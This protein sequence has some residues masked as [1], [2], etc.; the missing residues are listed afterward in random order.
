MA[1]FQVPDIY[2]REQSGPRRPSLPI[3]LPPKHL[4]FHAFR[5]NFGADLKRFAQ[6]LQVIRK[7]L[8]ESAN[9]G[10][11]VR[12]QA[13]LLGLAD[14]TSPAILQ[15]SQSADDCDHAENG[16]QLPRRS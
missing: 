11:Q 6:P 10:A 15:N 8:F 12:L 7:F 2:S 14:F 3:A 9:A 1:L 5:R 13:L 4:A 16:T